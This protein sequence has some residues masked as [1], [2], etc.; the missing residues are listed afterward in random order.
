MWAALR[1][2]RNAL[3]IFYELLAPQFGSNMFKNILNTWLGEPQILSSEKICDINWV[4]VVFSVTDISALNVRL[5]IYLEIW[6]FD[7]TRVSGVS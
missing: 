7:Q 2:K 5:G 1:G 6:E 4:K 3:F